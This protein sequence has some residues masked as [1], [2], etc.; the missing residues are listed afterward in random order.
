MIHPAV[1]SAVPAENAARFQQAL[2][3]PCGFPTDSTATTATGYSR[4][5]PNRHGSVLR[6]VERPSLRLC[7]LCASVVQPSGHKLEIRNP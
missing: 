7:T 3:K 1:D 5:P 4:C 6:R 2:G